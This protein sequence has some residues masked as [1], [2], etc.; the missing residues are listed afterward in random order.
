MIR[1]FL[2]SKNHRAR[3]AG[4]NLDYEGSI[5]IDKALMKGANIA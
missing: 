1:S 2:K 5:T 4:V 3:V